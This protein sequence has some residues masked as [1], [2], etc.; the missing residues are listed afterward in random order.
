MDIH[1]LR[2]VTHMDEN[3]GTVAALLFFAVFAG[4]AMT[5][6]AQGGEAT[7]Q[8]AAPTYSSS[9]RASITATIV[10]RPS[11]SCDQI[12]RSVTVEIAAIPPL[13]D[14]PLHPVVIPRFGCAAIQGMFGVTAK[15]TSI[16]PAAPIL[17]VPAGTNSTDRP[18]GAGSPG[19]RHDV[20]VI[21]NFE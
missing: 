11:F 16:E 3:Q 1:L 21:Y 12:L 17:A 4:F 7:S 8:R 6:Q 2:E 14:D 19:H 10:E 20:E 9:A 18:G 15:I 5:P 13:P